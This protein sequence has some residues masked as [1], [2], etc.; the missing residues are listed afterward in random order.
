MHRD[1][2]RPT[3]GCS[4]RAACRVLPLAA[5]FAC[6]MALAQ[7]AATWPGKPVRWIAPYPPG[8][9]S[10]LVARAVG[11]RLS[12]QLGQPVL[13]DNRPGVGGA[14]GSALAAR[15]AP[16][17]Y[18][19]LL[20]N[21]A[22]LTIAPHI[23]SN[24]GYD[25]LAD[26]ESVT[27]LATGPT[28]LVVGPSVQVRNVTELIAL[29]KARPGMLKYGSGG[30]GTPAHLTTE[31]LRMMTGVQ[32]VH[33]PYK[34]TGQSVSD[35]LGGHIDLVFASMPI[36]AAHVRSGKLRALAASSAK[37]TAVAPDLPTMDEAGVPG[38]D[39]VTW[40]G[41]VVPKGTPA[42]VVGRLNATLRKSLDYADTRERFIA[43]G[44]DAQGS[45]P[46]AFRD[47]MASELARYGKMVKDVGLK[48]D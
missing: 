9:S 23:H 38:F 11:I 44:I 12:E 39:M 3:P 40:W 43:L 15:A 26:F 33:V 28:I 41:V 5:A 24:L 32:M 18:T 34:G 31:L 35:L 21:I 7:P 48:N 47:F 17:G 29:A 1:S 30:A 13:I 45:T 46:E 16:D 36:T 22:P 10:D 20:A 27:L 4:I 19:L 37:R 25:T 42:P 8:G 14:L 6:P 2:L